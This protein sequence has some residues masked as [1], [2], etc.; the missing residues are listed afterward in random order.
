MDLLMQII[1]G[2]LVGICASAPLGPVGI[3]V[4]QKTLGFG[5]K[6]G[7]ITG[8]GAAVVDTI[9]AIIAIFFLAMAQRF[10]D[11][12]EVAIMIAGG[13]VVA[14]LGVAMTLK[15]P[16]RK[17]EMDTQKSKYSIAGFFQAFAI[18]ITNPGAILIMFAL[19]AFF[20][21]DTESDM[22]RVGPTLLAV[23]GGCVLYW[24][25]FSLLFSVWRKKMSL[26]WLLWIN[27]VL[28]IIVGIIGLVLF[29]DGLYQLIFK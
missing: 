9:Y 1:K 17:L 26:R 6:T 4:I 21:V 11:A 7:F 8:L 29:A 14:A 20:G 15:D 5:H 23:S 10:L 18:C 25:L 27:R 22:M 19:F 28:G 24:F 3:L 16:F 2:V 12:N 13:L